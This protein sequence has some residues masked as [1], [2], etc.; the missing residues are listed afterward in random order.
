MGEVRS[1]CVDQ[2]KPMHNDFL[3]P[4]LFFFYIFQPADSSSRDCPGG[5]IVHVVLDLLRSR[6]QSLS[7]NMRLYLPICNASFS[8]HLYILDYRIE[9]SNLYI[10]HIQIRTH[11]VFQQIPTLLFWMQETRIQCQ[12]PNP[13]GVVRRFRMAP[14]LLPI[15][16]ALFQFSSNKTPF[17]VLA[18]LFHI[19]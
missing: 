5:N 4:G 17:V 15:A 16:K 19:F 11:S 13:A 2:Q 9:K 1:N 6:P 3:F 7:K 10:K 14:M 12:D 8:T 18:R